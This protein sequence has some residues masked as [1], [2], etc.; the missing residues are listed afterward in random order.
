MFNIYSFI[1]T[2][3]LF[4]FNVCLFI[5]TICLF[6]FNI[7]LFAFNICLFTFNICLFIFSICLF[8]FNICLFTFNICVYS[9]SVFIQVQHLCSLN[10]I[11]FNNYIHLKCNIYVLFL[12]LSIHSTILYSFK[13]YCVSLLR[14]EVTHFLQLINRGQCRRVGILKK[15]RVRFKFQPLP[16]F[17]EHTYFQEN[18]S[19]PKI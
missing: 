3:C 10:Y 12:I 15:Y 7:C 13:I 14:M 1:F 11:S 9:V 8:I 6:I 2:I 16:L 19:V 17:L 18:Q 5:F 4:T